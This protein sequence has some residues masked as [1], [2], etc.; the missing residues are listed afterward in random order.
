L[1]WLLDPSEINGDSLN[2][3]RGEACRHFRN[4]KREYLRDKIKELTMNSKNRNIKDLHKGIKEVKRGHQLR[5][6]F[7]KDE[8]GDLLARFF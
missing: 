7:V 1:Q 6:N 2:S 8:N 5:N 3:E 4:K